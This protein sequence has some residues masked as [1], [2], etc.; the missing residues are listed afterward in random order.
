MNLRVLLSM[1]AI[2]AA[3]LLLSGAIAV[4]QMVHPGP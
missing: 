2:S 3:G 4:V 1:F